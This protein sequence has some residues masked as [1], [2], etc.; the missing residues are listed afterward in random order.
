MESYRSGTVNSTSPVVLKPGEKAIILTGRSPVGASFK[1]NIC[2]GYL[3]Q[4]QTFIPDLNRSCPSP[5]DE[6]SAR[7]SGADKEA[8]TTTA[9]NIPRCAVVT[10]STAGGTCGTFL[11]DNLNYNSCVTSHRNDST[12]TLKTWRLYLDRNTELWGK[13]RE[14]I[15]LYDQNGKVVDTFSY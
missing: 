2:T 6:I 8:C 7:Y 15:T 1:E 5:A 9:E 13:A 11:K 10:S 4:Y 3:G 14:T 12:F